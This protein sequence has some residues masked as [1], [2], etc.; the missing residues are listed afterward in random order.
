MRGLVELALILGVSALAAT[1]H[2]VVAGRPAP[3]LVSTTAIAGE[4][5]IALKP[6]E[7][8][9]AEILGE[10]GGVLWVDAR[11]PEEWQENG[12][13]GSVNLSPRATEPLDAQIAAIVDRLGGSS[14]VVIYCADAGCGLSHEVAEALKPYRDLFGGDIV[15]LHGGVEVLRAAGVIRSSSAGSGS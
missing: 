6:G 3:V 7:V 14:R 4:P 2:W 1:A 8:M 11:A 10:A 12:V 13:H 9:L 15:V 5:V